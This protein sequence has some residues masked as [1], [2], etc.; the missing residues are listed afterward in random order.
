[1][2]FQENQ[3][4]LNHERIPRKDYINIGESEQC[5]LIELHMKHKTIVRT[6]E[7]T[8]ESRSKQSSTP[9]VKDIISASTVLHQSSTPVAKDIISASTALHQSSTPVAKDIISASTAL[10]QS[11]TPIVEDII[12][13]SIALHQ[14]ST[15]V[16]KD[17]NFC[18]HLHCMVVVLNYIQLK[19]MPFLFS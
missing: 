19:T 8:V 5:L 13:A 1:M 2:Q 17:I 4:Y 16:V 12:S 7:H 18:I 10:H 9:V 11:S 14:S 6:L 3:S 15:P